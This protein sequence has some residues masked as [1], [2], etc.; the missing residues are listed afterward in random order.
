M[1]SETFTGALTGLIARQ[2][3]ARAHDKPL[4]THTD[5]EI[6][7]LVRD[8]NTEAFGILVRRHED[9]V[10]TL[11]RGIVS[12]EEQAKDIAQEAFL[13]AYRAIRRFERRSSFKTW[14]YRIAYNTAISHLKSRDK[15]H[16]PINE[17]ELEQTT[18]DNSESSLKITL[19]K[20]IGLLKPEL[21]AVII[22]H[23]YDDLKYEEIAEILACP[24]GTVKIRLFRAKHELKRLWDKYAV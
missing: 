1:N 11:A 15:D 12:C 10:F 17:I 4:A 21:K 22:F 8:G 9:F 2:F 24:I 18:F 23:Y 6:T 14:L 13:R 19:E 16:V 20:L 3:P 7:D 5:E